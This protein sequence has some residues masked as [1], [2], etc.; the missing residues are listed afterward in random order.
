MPRGFGAADEAPDALV[1]LGAV[2]PLAGVG[3]LD[4]NDEQSSSSAASCTHPD[5]LGPEPRQHNPHRQTIRS[6]TLQL[7][8]LAAQAPSVAAAD[9]ATSGRLVGWS[10]EP[11]D[12]LKDIAADAV[13]P[14]SLLADAHES[15]VL[16]YLF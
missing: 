8:I 12:V 5:T 14:R 9:G 1:H 6:G 10:V 15:V 2:V 11:I 3:H 4:V 16:K 13:S 7:T